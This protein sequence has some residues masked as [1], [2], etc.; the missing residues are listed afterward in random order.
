MGRFMV[1][2]RCILALWALFAV[3][4]LAHATETIHIL[5][6]RVEFPKEDPDDFTT[7]GNGLFDMRAPAEA[8]VA[9]GE[10]GFRYPYDLPPHDGRFLENHLTALKHYVETTSHN[11]TTITWEIFP[12]YPA[13][14][15]VAPQSLGAYGSGSTVAEQTRN[16]VQFLKDALTLSQTQV[17]ALSRFQSFLVFNASISLQGVLSAE[18]PALVLT[19]QEISA[20]GV[21]I[22]SDVHTAWFI[23]Q[24]IQQP[25]GVIGLN[26]A[27]AK[28]FLASRGL[29]VLSNTRTGGAAVGAWT[30]MDVG[31]DNLIELPRTRPGGIND[32]V[33]VL[34]FVPCQPSAWEQSRLGWLS[35]VVVRSDTTLTLAGLASET[36]LPRAIKVVLTDDEYLLLEL[37][38]S[39]LV[40]EG[41]HPG[42]AY[43]NGDT[44]GVWLRPLDGLYDAYVPGSGVVI[45]HVNSERIRLWE[46]EN[47]INAQPDRP[48]IMVVEAD[49]YRDIGVTNMLGHPRSNEGIGSRNDPFPVT[50]EKALYPDGDP[51]PGHPT[52]R[53]A[54]GASSGVGISFAPVGTA[55]DTVSVSVRWRTANSS[56]RISRFIGG[57]VVGGVAIRKVP[58]DGIQR[59]LIV[60]ATDDWNVWAFTDSLQPVGNAN[61]LIGRFWGDIVRKPIIEADGAVLIVGAVTNTRY[62]Y[63]NGAWDI[64]T[65]VVQTPPV[66]ATMTC[67]LLRDIRKSDITV[68]G[69][70]SIT[71]N[72]FARG[73]WIPENPPPPA[74]LWSVV[75]DSLIAPLSLGD[76]DQDGFPDIL[77]TSTR[78]VEVFSR[79]GARLISYSLGRADSTEEFVGSALSTRSGKTIVAGKK[80]FSVFSGLTRQS[81]LE[82]IPLPA[83]AIGSPA[84]CTVAG[85]GVRAVAGTADGWLLDI[86]VVASDSALW[87]QMY[88]D[89]GSSFA[90][91]ET[92]LAAPVAPA[93]ELM[94]KDRVF[95]YPSP[96]GNTEGI[97]RFFLTSQANVSVRIYTSM[98]E[99]VW[100]RDVP[101]GTTIANADNEIRWPGGT[102]FA[103][104]LYVARVV[105]RAPDGRQSAVTIPVGIAK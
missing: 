45:Y 84:L 82:T 59:T 9:E 79:S 7:G 6:L 54:N 55:K 23:P 66:P 30:L 18:L 34:G 56:A 24:Q 31:S 74:V 5:A 40:T 51:A 58:L 25:G 63:Q 96:V 86:P 69:S 98:G 16:W 2:R 60:A 35:P 64:G 68:A 11:Q 22:P 105:A 15:Y 93:D 46:P 85:Q 81:P 14:A 92:L 17:G 70:N 77:A 29:P 71:A 72:T 101:G 48:G 38:R 32:T 78:G 19:T 80:G 41:R 53:L 87:S 91:D 50:G 28:T 43:S 99:L 104:G 21:S 39:T 42:I 94:P 100:E 75:T 90:L 10:A 83:A 49:G 76:V 8:L 4:S 12:P 67:H 65:S 95:F 102:R 47:R 88:G 57:S 103:S 33:R 27:F 1:F 44:A 52:V 73:G 13:T 89:G 61:G 26:G 20:S 37:R 36:S 62:R 97:L 3:A